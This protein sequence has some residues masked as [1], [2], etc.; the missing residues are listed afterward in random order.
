MDCRVR[1]RDE[2]RQAKLASDFLVIWF[3]QGSG[4]YLQ[5]LMDDIA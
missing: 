5:L 3:P 2:S 1:R 4:P